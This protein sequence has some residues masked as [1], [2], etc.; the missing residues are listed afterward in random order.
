MPKTLGR[1]PRPIL[2][3]TLI[4]TGC[5]SSDDRLVELGEQS[6]ERQAEQNQTIAEQS[7]A[8]AETTRRFVEAEVETRGELSRIQQDLVERD[9][10][11]RL[12]LAALHKETQAAMQV[13]RQSVDRQREGL[14]AERRQLANERHRAPIVAAAVSQVGMILACLLP[15]GLCG[16]LLYVMRHSS[17]A[18]AAVTE[19]LIEEIVA[20][21]PRFLPVVKQT[22]ALKHAPDAAVSSSS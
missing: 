19:L 2:L 4:L 1:L 10:Q 6:C 22:A 7:R 16:Y 20:E 15:L 17:E 8:F 21:E 9:A 14:E 5:S 3:L 12:E 13:E 11:C 18:D